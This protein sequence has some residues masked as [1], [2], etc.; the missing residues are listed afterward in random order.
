MGSAASTGRGRRADA[1][2]LVR[3]R[4]LAVRRFPVPGDSFA[5][6]AAPDPVD[7][8]RRHGADPTEARSAMTSTDIPKLLSKFEIEEADLR[9]VRA[10]APALKRHL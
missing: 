9:R 5:Y 1:T 10:A 4:V 7:A 2:A 6:P 8:A 3:L